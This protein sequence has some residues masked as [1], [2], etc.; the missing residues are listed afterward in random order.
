MTFLD[1]YK[2]IVML[3]NIL[4]IERKLFS[5]ILPTKWLKQLQN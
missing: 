1:S 5:R 3:E 4:N 2:N